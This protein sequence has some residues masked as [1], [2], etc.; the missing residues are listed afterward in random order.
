MN[1]A[2]GV[3]GFALMTAYW[4]GIGGLAT[5][6]RW[7]I[8]AII[9]I[10]FL[11]RAP[12]KLTITH[13]LGAALVGWLLLSLV[14]S[15]GFMDGIDGA[16][17][18][19]LTALLFALGSTLE[20]N[21]LRALTA[22]AALGLTVSSIAAVAQYYGWQGLPTYSAPAGLFFNGGILA[23]A[24]AVVIAALIAFRRWWFIPLLLPALLLPMARGPVLVLLAAAG[25]SLMIRRNKMFD[26][27]AWAAIALLVVYVD[28]SRWFDGGVAERIA[29]WRD[30][31]NALTPLG[32]G[33]GSFG[34]TFPLHAHYFSLADSRPTFPHNEWLWLAYE[35]GVVAVMLGAAF[36]YSL[37]KS[38]DV[39]CRIVFMVIAGAALYAMPLHDPA[40]VLFGALLAGYCARDRLAVRR[41]AGS[42]GNP[43]RAGLAR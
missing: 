32:Y 40:T 10:F 41:P 25:I 6:P 13:W 21:T 20:R 38:A 42:C 8:G 14:W 23:E 29:L 28:L 39:E 19:L 9:A 1:M 22:G 31:V 11:F 12:V 34:V 4:S 7:S 16:W 33:L 35:G 5:T 24:A 37:W 2:A 18:L 3:A 30:T 27:A 15:Q 17:K 26:L 43:L 36:C